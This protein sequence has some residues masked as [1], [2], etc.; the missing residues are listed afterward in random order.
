MSLDKN[1]SFIQCKQGRVLKCTELVSVPC[2]LRKHSAG[3]FYLA[4][5]ENLSQG[6]LIPRVGWRTVLP[7]VS[8]RLPALTWLSLTA[9]AWLLPLSLAAGHLGTERRPPWKEGDASLEMSPG[10]LTH[11]QRIQLLDL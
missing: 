2:Y 10:K 5:V 9:V 8:F 3:L 7:R 11:P 4:K 1:V 6:D